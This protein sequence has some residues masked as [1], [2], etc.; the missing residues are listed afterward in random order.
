MMFAAYIFPVLESMAWI[1]TWSVIIITILDVFLLFTERKVMVFSRS[2]HSRMDLGDENTVQLRLK[3]LT[4]SRWRFIL[5]EAFPHEMQERKKRFTGVIE[6]NG[7]YEVSYPF[8]PLSRGKHFF[9]QP[10]LLLHSLLGLAERKV[11]FKIE[12]FF[13]VHPSIQQMRKH[14]L[15]VFRQQKLSSG[16]KRIRMIGNTNEFEQIKSYVQGDDIKRINWKATS[17][18]NELM[19]NQFQEE[20]AQHVYCIIDKGRSMQNKFDGMTYLDYAINSTLVLSNIALRKGDR[21]GLV[22]FS[23]KMGV[24]IPAEKK[25]NQLRKISTELF[26]QRTHFLEPDFERLYLNLKRAIRTRALLI[27]FT[28]FETETAM[29]RHLPMLRKLNNK[30]LLVLVFFENEEIKEQAQLNAVTSDELY[31]QV[32]SER[33]ATTQHRIALELKRNGIQTV[34]TSPDRLS[35]NSINK[36]L[37][38]KS[39]VRI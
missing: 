22:T 24:I 11:E 38:L 15:M 3:N 7:L 9:G 27:L 37:E 32:I 10:V 13:E 36:Y 18:R 4:S 30:H 33:L 23:D 28:H 14:E 39:K 29:R 19:T 35:V 5:A 6:P 21:A 26:D 34:L 12:D 2:F 25:E 20:K 8:K 1:A 31:L 16:L 17:R